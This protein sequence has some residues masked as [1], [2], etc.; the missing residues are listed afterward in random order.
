MTYAP[1]YSPSDEETMMGWISPL[2]VFIPGHRARRRWAG[3]GGAFGYNVV[4][5]D[6]MYPVVLMLYQPQDGP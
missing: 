2:A 1:W 4:A 3:F 5:K 6:V